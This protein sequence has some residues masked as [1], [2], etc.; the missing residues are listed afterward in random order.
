MYYIVIKHF[1]SCCA[2]L[3]FRGVLNVSCD[4]DNLIHGVKELKIGILWF[5]LY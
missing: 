4:Y 5:Q 1:G 3:H 2:C